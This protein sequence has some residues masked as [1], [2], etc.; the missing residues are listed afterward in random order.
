VSSL[1]RYSIFE[2]KRVSIVGPEVRK[3]SRHGDDDAVG[4]GD[5][6]SKLNIWL[7]FSRFSEQSTVGYST[8]TGY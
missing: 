1:K 2:V 4:D 6:C 5:R 8:C 3:S 7:W